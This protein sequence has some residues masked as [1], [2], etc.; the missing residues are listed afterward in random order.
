MTTITTVTI[1]PATAP[2]AIATVGDE[3]EVEPPESVASGVGESVA[4]AVD[5]G[6]GC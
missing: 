2:Q 4:G 5:D 3:D 1:T 6:E